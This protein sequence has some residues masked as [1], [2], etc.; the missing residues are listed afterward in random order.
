[1]SDERVTNSGRPPEQEGSAPAP[2]N[3]AT[4]QHGDHWVL[5]A[6]ERA[7]GFVRPVRDSYR[8]V[9]CGGVTRMPQAIAQTYA[10]QPG[11]YGQTFCVDCSAYLPVGEHGEFVW[12]DDGKKMGV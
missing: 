1:M 12:L 10:R 4:G 9:K 8:H 6:E 7:K 2:I 5:S 11:F 3:P